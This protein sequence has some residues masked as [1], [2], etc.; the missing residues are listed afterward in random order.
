MPVD[1]VG[2]TS[3]GALMAALYA[4]HASTT[5]M[6]PRVKE[7]VGALS[8]PRHLL[9]DLTLPVL[10]IF[11]GKGVDRI[12]RTVLG[13]TDIEDLWLSFFCVSTNLTSGGLSTHTSGTVWRYVRASM[14]ILGMLPPVRDDQTGDLLVD[15]GYLNAIPVDVLRERMGVETV[16]V[17]DVEDNDYT[18][19]RNL[20]PH[21]GGLGGWRLLWE[22]INPFGSWLG[23]WFLGPS[24][25]ELSLIHI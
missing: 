22:R 20:T 4:R 9:T 25:D 17:V 12:L 10:S 1:C 6:L 19:F 24:I 2:G 11:S 18:A 5:H 3:Q 8:S 14:T 21:D 15:G 23:R 7:L 16:V 13:D